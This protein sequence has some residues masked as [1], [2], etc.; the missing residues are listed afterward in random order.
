L[1]QEII[2]LLSVPTKAEVQD[3]KMLSTT[4]AVSNKEEQPTLLIDEQIEFALTLNNLLEKHLPDITK[5][6]G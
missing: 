5:L 2:K 6:V 3:A 4:E 1:Y